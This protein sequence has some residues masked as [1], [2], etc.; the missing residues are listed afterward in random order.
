MSSSSS[1]KS[2]PQ[3]EDDSVTHFN[4]LKQGRVDVHGQD[5]FDKIQ[6]KI[7]SSIKKGK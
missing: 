1:V 4:K 7:D 5:S 6:K 3:Q 2:Q